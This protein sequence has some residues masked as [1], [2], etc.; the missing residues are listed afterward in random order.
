M[1]RDGGSLPPARD[2]TSEVPSNH[3]RRHGGQWYA[4]RNQPGQKG[5]QRTFA[6]DNRGVGESPLLFE[7]VQKILQ[8][9]VVR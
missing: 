6:I 2:D 7:K 4:L 8:V 5:S 3:H 1:K 9:M